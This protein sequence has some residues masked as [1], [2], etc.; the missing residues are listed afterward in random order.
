ME[1]QPSE[2]VTRL[3]ASADR[4]AAQAELVPLVYDEL[5][6]LA[7]NRMRE[8]RASHTLQTTALVH[9]AYVRMLGDRQL[10]WEARTQFFVAAS[11]AMRRVLLDHA[12]RR[13]SH[14]RGGGARLVELEELDLGSEATLDAAL[15][16][17][18]ALERLAAEEPRAAEVVRLRFYAGLEVEDTARALGTSRRTVLR[19]WAFARARLQQLLGA[20]AGP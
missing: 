14:K 17:D 1:P 16:F 12:R 2:R 11:A 4:A 15:D 7:Q 9:E 6:A 20:A 13:R 5:R 8:E 10:D 19:E 3:L 18:A